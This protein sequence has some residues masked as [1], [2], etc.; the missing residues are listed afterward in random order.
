MPGGLEFGEKLTAGIL[1]FLGAAAALSTAAHAPLALT[2]SLAALAVVGG[3]GAIVLHWA[4]E[5]ARRRGESTFA[6]AGAADPRQGGG[7]SRL[8]LRD[9]SGVRGE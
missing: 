4:R 8:V 6:L 7:R 3:L 2:I 9:R 1:T 5:R